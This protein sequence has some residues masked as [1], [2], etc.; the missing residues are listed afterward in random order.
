MVA[1]GTIAVAG[2]A[3]LWRCGQDPRKE[4]IQGR[5]ATIGEIEMAHELLL[6]KCHCLADSV[7]LGRLWGRHSLQTPA[8]VR[9]RCG[10]RSAT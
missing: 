8:A 1:R 2:T 4:E 10:Q 7:A 5:R 6:D 3:A 9:A